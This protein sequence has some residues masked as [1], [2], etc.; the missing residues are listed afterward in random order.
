[1]E[2]SEASRA[3]R[4]ACAREMMR[5]CSPVRVQESRKGKLVEGDKGGEI[6]IMVIRMRR[7]AVPRK[8]KIGA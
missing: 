7:R 4:R 1:M 3:E 8:G 6:I 2:G 5:C